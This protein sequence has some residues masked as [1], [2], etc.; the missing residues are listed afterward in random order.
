[1]NLYKSFVPK[2]G[3]K[4]DLRAEIFNV[5]NHPRF[6]APNTAFGGEAFGTISSDAAGYLPRYFQFGLLFEF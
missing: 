2:E 5:A 3:M 4:I 6:A 1:M